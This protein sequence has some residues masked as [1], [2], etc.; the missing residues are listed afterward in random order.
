MVGTGGQ[1]VVGKNGGQHSLRFSY[2]PSSC[3]Q[4][5]SMRTVWTW[6]ELVCIR[7]WVSPCVT[8]FRG[9][10]VPRLHILALLWV[11]MGHCVL[12]MDLR[13]QWLAWGGGVS[14][15]WG[16]LWLRIQDIV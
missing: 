3:M 10:Y 2:L 9:T 5:V 6:G 13:H 16:H 1:H 12:E 7:G 8:D 15:I 4:T 14:M 11:S